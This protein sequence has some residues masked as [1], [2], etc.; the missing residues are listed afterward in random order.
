MRWIL[1]LDRDDLFLLAAI[2]G[3]IAIALCV[4]YV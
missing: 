4:A 1:A 2:V 3:C